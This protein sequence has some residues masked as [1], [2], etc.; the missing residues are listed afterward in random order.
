MLNKEKLYP[1]DQLYYYTLGVVLT[2]TTS[3]PKR[4][5]LLV[6]LTL[7][8]LALL[9]LVGWSLYWIGSKSDNAPQVRS[10]H[11]NKSKENITLIAASTLKEN[12]EDEEEPVELSA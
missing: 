11:N 12:V 8:A 3:K 6:I 5:R 9:W 4:N 1:L 10:K 7:P 2:V